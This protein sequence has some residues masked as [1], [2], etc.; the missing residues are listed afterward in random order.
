MPL[1]PRSSEATWSSWTPRLVRGWIACVVILAVSGCAG[2]RLGPTSGEPAGARS[3]QVAFFANQTIEPRL[4]EAVAHALRRSLQQ[5]GTYRLQTDGDADL[6]MTGVL[7]EYDRRPMAFRRRDIVSVQEYEARLTAR[8]TVVER[9]S[10]R[11]VLQRDVV[12]RT[13]YSVVSDLGS[14]ERQALPLLAQ[15]LARNA[16]TFLT[17]GSW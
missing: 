5:D 7:L 9:V 15:D 3:L 16:T 2:Y 14:A 13:T 10:G 4:P 11:K 12:G 17:E 6:V 8:V 1:P